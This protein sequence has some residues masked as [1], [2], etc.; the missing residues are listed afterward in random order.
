MDITSNCYGK[1]FFSCFPGHILYASW[2]W[3]YTPFTRYN[4]VKPFWQPVGCLFTR[5][6]R[7]SNR[8]S[9]RIDNRFANGFDNS[10]VRSTGCQTG[11]YNRFDNRLYTVHDTAGCQTGCHTGLTT[12]WMFVYTIQPAVKTLDN[13]FDNRLYRVNG[14]LVFWY[15]LYTGHLDSFVVIMIGLILLVLL[16]QSQLLLFFSYF[17]ISVTV[18]W[19]NTDMQCPWCNVQAAETD[20]RALRARSPLGR[21]RQRSANAQKIRRV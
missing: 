21:G 12:G 13:R 14:A 8:L 1:Y 18:N 9:Y 20:A 19:R 11:L 2:L 5:Y 4:L 17:V 16:L 10:H 3:R 7:L 6:S 15:Q